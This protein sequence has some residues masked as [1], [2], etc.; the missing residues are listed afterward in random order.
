MD[1][2]LAPGRI[3]RIEIRVNFFVLNL[4]TARTSSVES[5]L[6]S[7]VVRKFE[8]RTKAQASWKQIKWQSATPYDS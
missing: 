3:G 6:H 4:S 2:Q 5:C 1:R 7:K 8:S